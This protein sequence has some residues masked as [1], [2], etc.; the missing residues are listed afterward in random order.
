MKRNFLI[1]SLVFFALAACSRGSD[2]GAAVVLTISGD[3]TDANRGPMTPQSD[4]FLNWLGA[5]FEQAREFTAADLAAFPQVTV[6]ADYPAGGEEH[7]FTGPRLSDILDAAGAGGDTVTATAL[8]GFGAKI[9]RALID[10][11]DVILAT[12]RDGTPL[13]MGGFGPAQIVF[14][15]AGAQALRGMDDSLWAWGVVWIE[16]GGQ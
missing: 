15:R 6:T 10:E 7:S 16:A 8:D 12:S 5:D 2:H 11:Y 14:P 13:K 4:V 1:F 9:P 3:V